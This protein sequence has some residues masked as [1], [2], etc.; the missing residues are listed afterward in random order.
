MGHA[1]MITHSYLFRP[2]YPPVSP[3]LRPGSI[4]GEMVGSMVLSVLTMGNLHTKFSTKPLPYG[5][6]NLYLALH[7]NPTCAQCTCSRGGSLWVA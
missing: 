1:T 4:Y 2:Q 3:A 6:L 7:W 5:F